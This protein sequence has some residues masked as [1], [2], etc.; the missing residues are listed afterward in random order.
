L[1]LEKGGVLMLCKQGKMCSQVLK[2][3]SVVCVLLAGWGFAQGDVW[4]ASTQWLLIAL[5]LG[6]WAIYLKIE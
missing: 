6:V 3:T 5:V 2:A 4:L 1:F